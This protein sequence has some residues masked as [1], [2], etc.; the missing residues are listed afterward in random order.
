MC[1]ITWINPSQHGFMKGRS[2]LTNFISFYDQVVRLVGEGKALDTVYLDFSEAFGVVSHS[3][4][5]G[6]LAVRGLDGY[7]VH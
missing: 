7:T 4:L 6:K 3:I 1:G 2:C 5:L